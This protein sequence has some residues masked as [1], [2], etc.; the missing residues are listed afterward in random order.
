MSNY[1]DAT[2]LEGQERIKKA[3][4]QGPLRGAPPEA[5]RWHGEDYADAAQNNP[6]GS[7]LSLLE[8]PCWSGFG[9]GSLWN[10]LQLLWKTHRVI[11]SCHIT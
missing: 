9:S 11:G 7:L 8:P 2:L 3:E 10:L 1:S 6:A 4:I 5:Q